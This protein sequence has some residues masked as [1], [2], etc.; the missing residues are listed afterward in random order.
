LGT[1]TRTLRHL[2]GVDDVDARIGAAAGREGD[3]DEPPLR[4]LLAHGHGS[5]DTMSV[6]S[7]QPAALDLGSECLWVQERRHACG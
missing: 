7:G 3:G 2:A 5:S 6:Q 1:E 4:L